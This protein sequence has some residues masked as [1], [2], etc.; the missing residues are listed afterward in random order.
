MII[1]LMIYRNKASSGIGLFKSSAFVSIEDSNLF[2][3]INAK[4]WNG[5]RYLF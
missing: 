1:F 2:F 4:K 3:R 5:I